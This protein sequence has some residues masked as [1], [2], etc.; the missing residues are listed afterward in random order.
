MS[1]WTIPEQ[2]YDSQQRMNTL[3]LKEFAAITIATVLRKL[4][5]STTWKPKLDLVRNK[6]INVA[7]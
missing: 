5:C 2:Q 3:G 6:T 7:I 4:T 1:R